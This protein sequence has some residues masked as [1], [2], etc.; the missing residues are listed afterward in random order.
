MD[1]TSGAWRMPTGPHAVGR[2]VDEIAE[3]RRLRLVTHYPADVS[4][5]PRA[6]YLAPGEYD[7]VVVPLLEL[8]GLPSDAF[9]SLKDKDI[10]SCD[11]ARAARGHH[12]LVVFSPGGPS[13]PTQNT[14]L[15]EELASLGYVVCSVGRPGLSSG[16]RYSDG[17]V[18]SMLPDFDA[19]MSSF[20]ASEFVDQATASVARRHELYVDAASGDMATFQAMARD[21]ARAAADALLEGAVGR[22]VGLPDVLAVDRLIYAGHS[23]GGSASVSTADAD[24]RATAAVNIDGL[25]FSMDMHNRSAR[26]PVLDLTADPQLGPF[27]FWSLNSF[28]FEPHTTAGQDARVPR[29]FADGA[30]HLDFMD[31]AL[32]PPNERGLVSPSLIDGPQLVRGLATLIHQFVECQ[33]AN[34]HGF[35]RYDL[36]SVRTWAT[37]G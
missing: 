4:T 37:A 34:S 20:Q 27:G 9:K 1:D 18:A 19:A 16:V 29:L 5:G 30:T 31:T 35:H 2:T 11:D 23:L 17:S 6:K 13:W 36:S 21:D 10:A 7:A 3:A 28:C 15:A 33:T 14:A 8:F 22:A 12:P 25:H 24:A 26:T 32:L